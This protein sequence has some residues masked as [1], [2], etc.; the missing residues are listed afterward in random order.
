VQFARFRRADITLTIAAFDLSPDSVLSRVPADVRLA[1]ARDPATPV[2]VARVSPAGPLGILAVQSAWRPA[3]LSLEVLGVGTPWVARRRV[4]VPPDPGGLPP[5]LSDLLLFA[6]ADVLP[7][8]L[9]GALPAALGA[10]VARVGQRLGLYWEMYEDIADPTAGV[11]I[12]VTVMKARARSDEPY[13]IGRPECPLQVNSPVT[14][15]WR[16][17]PGAR[18]HGA[19]RAVALDLRSL[20]RGRYVVTVRVSA[21]RLRGCSTRDLE[22]IAR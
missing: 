18:P 14:L 20:S 12:G 22:V 4:M 10:P 11:E 13:P 16:E 6:P 7:G 1:V 15:R 17:E 8:S 21:G 5:I 2:A 3:V 19:A 9:E